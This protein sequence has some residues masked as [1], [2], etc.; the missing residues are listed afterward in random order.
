MKQDDC[1][2]TVYNNY[3]INCKRKIK[4]Y[5]IGSWNLKPKHLQRLAYALYKLLFSCNYNGE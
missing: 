2:S 5:K 4:K 1:F 3:R